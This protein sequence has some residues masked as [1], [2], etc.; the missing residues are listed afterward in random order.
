GTLVIGMSR[1]DADTLDPTLAASF[2]SI[3]VLRSI[4]ERLYD[5]KADSSV[6]PELALRTPRIS[7]D[8]LTY[9]IPLRPG[10]RFNDGTPFNAAAV[11]QSLIRNMRLPLSMRASDLSSIASVKTRGSYAVVIHLKTPFAPLL[12]T[13][14]THDGI[15]MSPTQLAKGANFGADPVCVG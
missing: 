7:K 12:V 6:I 15:V 13:L 8:K 11:Q 4:C 14:A 3:E 2:S 9:T 10:L 5:F 1:G